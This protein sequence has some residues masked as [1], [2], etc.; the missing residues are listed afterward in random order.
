VGIPPDALL[1]LSDDRPPGSLELLDAEALVLEAAR[2]R[3][4]V[5]ALAAGYA[6]QER[7]VRLATRNALPLPQLSINRT[8][9]TSAIWTS[10]AGIGMSLPLWNRNRGEISIALATRA[11]LSA[12]YAA[13]V[14]RIRADVVAQ[15]EDLRAIEVQRAALARHVS[16]LE[17]SAGVMAEAMREGSL[18]L[19]TYATVRIALLDK[20]LTLAALQQANAEGE[21]ALE[22]ALGKFLWE[23]P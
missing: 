7:G 9:D 12:E 6:A 20:Q 15:L 2:S 5:R 22:T 14:L 19:L 10:G 1:A 16:E 18:P 3:L 17:K 4:D 11:Q 21:V 8:R 13:R 23:K